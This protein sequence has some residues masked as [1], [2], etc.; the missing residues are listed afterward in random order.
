MS[1]TNPSFGRIGGGFMFGRS[2][3]FDLYLTTISINDRN[4]I[5][6]EERAYLRSIPRLEN[7]SLELAVADS[8]EGYTDLT[9]GQEYAM[10]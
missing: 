3:A 7:D 10:P 5:L 6:A 4:A 9:A 2:S 8:M 1:N